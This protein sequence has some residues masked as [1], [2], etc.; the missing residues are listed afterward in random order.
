[1]VYRLADHHDLS[2]VTLTQA[3]NGFGLTGHTNGQRPVIT[4]RILSDYSE[5]NI[6]IPL[7]L[8]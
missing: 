1:M 5:K 8:S 3:G 4:D 6:D 2:L 7:N